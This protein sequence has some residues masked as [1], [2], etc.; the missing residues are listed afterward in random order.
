MSFVVLFLVIALLCLLI[1]GIARVVAAIVVFFK[2]PWLLLIVS[3]IGIIRYISQYSVLNFLVI[4]LSVILLVRLIIAQFGVFV[5]KT[6]KTI[7]IDRQDYRHALGRAYG[8]NFFFIVFGLLYANL[9][10]LLAVQVGGLSY[11]EY[12]DL[13]LF[14]GKALSMIGFGPIKWGV[15]IIAGI[16]L[17]WAFH[18][19]SDFSMD[20]GAS[21]IKGPLQNSIT[22]YISSHLNIQI[23][24]AKNTLEATRDALFSYF[25]QQLEGD[26]SSRLT[27]AVLNVAAIEVDNRD[28]LLELLTKDSG[29]SKTNIIRCIPE[30][31]QKD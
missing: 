8:S 6:E 30:L 5:K 11:D 18:C 4:A 19:A 21:E 16:A 1:Y 29:L 15:L 10:Y 26:A 9:N 12:K 31:K 3:Y 22:K 28:E 20:C 23:V 14:A 27:E 7:T 25:E 24:P 2:I 17:L 13:G